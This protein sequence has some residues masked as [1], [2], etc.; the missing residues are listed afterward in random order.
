MNHEQLAAELDKYIRNFADEGD[1]RMQDDLIR[2]AAVVLR[3]QDK[4]IAEL[5]AAIEKHKSHYNSTCDC[6]FECDTGKAD[7]ELYAAL[8]AKR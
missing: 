6:G 7:Q 2:R 5:E 3:E 1:P 4:R 8:E